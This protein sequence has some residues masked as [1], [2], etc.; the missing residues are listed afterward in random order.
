MG[1]DVL[2]RSPSSRR[3][4]WLTLPEKASARGS[5]T[6]KHIPRAGP[7][8]G[9][10]R[11]LPVDAD[12]AQGHDWGGAAHDVHG[13]EYVAEEVA[14][15]PLAPDKV[16][17]ADKRHDRHS[18]REV[19]QRQG[20]YQVVGRLAKLLDEAHRNHHQA[21]ARDRQQRDERQNGADHNF[22]DS[23]VVDL[24]PAA[25]GIVRGCVPGGHRAGGHLRDP[26]QQVR[27]PGAR[28]RPGAVGA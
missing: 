6:S 18:H 7:R 8:D 27:R 4:V 14:K 1:V 15:D 9:A 26:A 17:D 12:H 20:H 11:A 23:A 21:V 19:G 10:A 13:D 22:L 24:L 2:K 25:G 5:A 16:C 28:D 3:E